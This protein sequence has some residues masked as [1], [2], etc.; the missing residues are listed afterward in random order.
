MPRWLKWL[1]GILLVLAIGGYIFMKSMNEPIPSGAT[2]PKAD[3]LAQK[4]LTAINNNAWDTTHIV[5]WSFPGG[6]DYI[7]DKRR[8]FTQVKWDNKRALIDLNTVQGKVWV[9]GKEIRDE[10][11][12]DIIQ[13]AW[14]YWCNDSFWLN[15]PAKAFDGGVERRYVENYNGQEALL[16]T[17]KGGGNTP[18]DSYL[19]IFGEDGLPVSYKMWVSIIPIGGIEATWKDWVTLSTGAKIASN[20]TITKMNVDIPITNLKAGNE[21]T[22]FGFDQ[23]PFEV[24][25][26]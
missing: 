18:G 10:S 23:D 12:A 21:I 20:H 7:W 13:K 2:G 17:Y 11:T 16:V 3:E 6:H 26:Q 22:T 19:W 5:Q 4:M 8:H 15:A 24:L 9:D 1:L 14:A 25:V